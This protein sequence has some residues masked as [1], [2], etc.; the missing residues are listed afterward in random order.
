[1]HLISIDLPQ[2][3]RNFLKEAELIDGSMLRQDNCIEFY[4]NFAGKAAKDKE[5]VMDPYQV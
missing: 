2:N 1:V 5:A 4:H 3:F